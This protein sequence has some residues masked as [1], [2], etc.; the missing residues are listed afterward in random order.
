MYQMYEDAA[1]VVQ[2]GGRDGGRLERGSV[3][4]GDQSLVHNILS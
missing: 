2:V 4:I 1:A 3:F